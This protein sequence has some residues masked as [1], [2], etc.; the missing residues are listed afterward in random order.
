MLKLGKPE[1]AFNRKN[2]RI[3]AIFALASPDTW[4]VYVEEE[5]K[6]IPALIF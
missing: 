6:L 3:K 5:L 2:L 4:I 1:A